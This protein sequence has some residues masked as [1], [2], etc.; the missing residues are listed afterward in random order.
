MPA[1]GMTQDTGRLIAWLKADGESVAKGEPIVEIETDKATVEI[2]APVSG[3][4]GGVL[5]NEGDVIPVGQ[6]MAWI[7]ALGESVPQQMREDHE[8]SL[9][10]SDAQQ[11]IPSASIEMRESRDGGARLSPASPKARRLAYERGLDVKSLT[12][13]GPGG[14][15]LAADVLSAD[16]EPIV[17]SPSPKP[18]T[19]W[20]V[21]VDRV[22][23]SW[24]SAPHFYLLREVY[25]GRLVEWRERLRERIEPKPTYTD[26]LVKLVAVALGRHQR[27]NASWREGRISALRWPLKTGWSYR[28]FT[29]QMS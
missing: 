2:E 19:I 26:L 14:A 22:T 29:G 12:G 18:S 1:L 25:A 6:T 10:S 11:A 20:Q 15:V 9:P 24:T 21:M 17:K 27:V 4:L 23:Q 8:S 7:L 5:A 16:T 3:I 28:L 13:T